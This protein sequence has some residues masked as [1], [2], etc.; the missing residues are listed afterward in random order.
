MGQERPQL[1]T[2]GQAMRK[3]PIQ[4]PRYKEE[5]CVH[6]DPCPSRHFLTFMSTWAKSER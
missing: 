5:S 4:A 3:D 1:T 2:V 6:Q